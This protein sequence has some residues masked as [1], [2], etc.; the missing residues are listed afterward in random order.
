MK[1]NQKVRST[2][3][4]HEG[5]AAVNLSPEQILMRSIVSCMLW[6]DHFYEDGESVA[7]RI[8]EYAGKVDPKKVADLAVSARN[9]YKIRHAPLWLINAMVQYPS[10]RP[11]VR[12][13]IRDVVSRADEL[14]ELLAMYWVNGRK[15]LPSQLKKGLADAFYKFDEYQL[16]KY[17]RKSKVK[18][19]D[20][21]IMT[22]PKPRDTQQADMWGRLIRDELKVPD[23]WEV[24]LST[25]GD[26][27]KTFTRLLEENK[28]GGLALLR[29]LRNM[30]AAGVSDSLISNAIKNIKST[31]ILPFRFIAAERHAPKFSSELEEA[32]F[33]CITDDKLP[34]HTIVLVDVSAS[35][36]D[37]V[38][39][40]ADITRLDA[41]CGIAILARE[42]C[43]RCSVYVFSDYVAQV[44]SRRGFALRDKI[45]SYKNNTTYLGKAVEHVKDV[46]HDRL[47][48]FTDEQSH[49][50][51]GSPNS[52]KSYMI[53]VSTYGK[54]VGFGKWVRVNGWSE[55]V[56]NFIAELE[57]IN[58]G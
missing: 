50:A 54:G 17:N 25:G 14:A 38:S 56:I 4:T 44:P 55:A 10:H 28:L 35:M 37:D 32:M 23:T 9:E 30:V 31:R 48:V 42:L 36:T 20:V 5:G 47:I 43:E 57:K 11:F 53:N 40:N 21:L 52:S 27:N 58:H 7:N 3:T 41:A 8:I 26:K 6:E 22:H 15:P 2:F 12:K 16:A 13:T 24:G 39:D 45:N 46:E 51:V 29:N 49:D 18:L 1:T 19:K 33:R 34:G